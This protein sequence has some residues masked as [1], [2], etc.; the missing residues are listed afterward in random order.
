MLNLPDIKREIM[1]N[2]NARKVKKGETNKFKCDIDY[3]RMTFKTKNRAFCPQEKHMHSEA[4]HLTFQIEQVPEAPSE[5][6]Q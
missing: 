2:S 6:S 1:D 4:M 3:C 5:C